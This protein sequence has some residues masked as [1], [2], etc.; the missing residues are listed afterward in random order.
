MEHETVDVLTNS[1]ISR[2][3]YDSNSRLKKVYEYVYGSVTD[4]VY[5][6]L[7]RVTAETITQGT[8]IISNTTYEYTDAAENGLYQKVKKTVVGDSNAP[9]IVTTQYTDKMGNTE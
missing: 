3:E 9:S 8:T 7:S 5:D 1:V 2:K 4:Y 6:D